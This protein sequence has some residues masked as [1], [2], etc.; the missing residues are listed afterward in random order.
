VLPL[1]DAFRR[2]RVLRQGMTACERLLWSRLKGKQ[3]GVKFRR[4][5]PI[6]RYILDFVSFER[7]L[8]IEVDGGQHGEAQQ[9]EHDQDRTNFLEKSGFRIVRFWNNEVMGNLEGVLAVVAAE[10][11]QRK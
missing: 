10:L 4:Q 7:T 1:T 3:L 8:I 2:A 11:E 9:M 5:A 6:G